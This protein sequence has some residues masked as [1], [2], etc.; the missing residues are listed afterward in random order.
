MTLKKAI[1]GCILGT[2]VG[3]ALGLPYE[4]L[5]PQRGK[6]IYG[7]P[8][9]HRLLFGRGLVSDDTEHTIFVA[10]AFI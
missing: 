8:D 5:N 9:R 2:A 6:K 1:I 3:D 7:Q 10:R 4:G